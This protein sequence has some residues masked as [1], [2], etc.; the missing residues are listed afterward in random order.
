MFGKSRG[1]FTLS[2]R[3]QTQLVDEC[4]K[5]ERAAAELPSFPEVVPEA[6]PEE[7]TEE[8]TDLATD[9]GMTKLSDV[10]GVARWALA[11]PLAAGST[12]DA[13]A[14]SVLDLLAERGV[15]VPVSLQAEVTA[16]LR[17]VG[18]QGDVRAQSTSSLAT[19]IVYTGELPGAELVE[20]HGKR[21]SCLS[22]ESGTVDLRSSLVYQKL[23]KNTSKTTLERALLDRD[24]SNR[25]LATVKDAVTQ[26]LYAASLPLAATRWQQVLGFAASHFRHDPAKERV[27]LWGYFFSTYLGLG[28]PEVRDSTTLM[29]MLAP[30]PG[31]GASAIESEMRPT[32]PGESL[33]GG[34]S[35]LSLGGGAAP[36]S[37][38]VPAELGALLMQ[39]Q[40]QLDTLTRALSGLSARGGGAPEEPPIKE[41]T[42]PKT[43]WP[44][45]VFC[46]TEHDPTVKCQK[47]K[48][49][50][51]L[52]SEHDKAQAK[53]R[54]E[55]E[56]AA[57]A[58]GTPG[59]APP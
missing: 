13:R 2:A 58:A 48:A 25:K 5:M 21:M 9:A 43:A 26:L 30:I 1:R 16:T 47:V 34:L 8:W 29:D 42:A 31:G 32:I 15:S 17:Q 56:A 7:L 49:A 27:Y 53:L 36:A 4:V 23:H 11:K 33:S 19:C 51:R 45:C 10:K 28:M 50:L 59:S 22:G 20:W 57:A 46:Q 40:T 55:A 14:A 12:P 37:G 18:D 39:Q 38:S 52:M 35:Q 41:L 6:D 54:K 24:P 44:K 3:Q